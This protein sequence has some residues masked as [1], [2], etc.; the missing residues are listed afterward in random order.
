MG[1]ERN[2]WRKLKQV[3]PVTRTIHAVFVSDHTAVD[4]WRVPVL[5][6]G[7][8]EELGYYGPDNG[9]RPRGDK[10][11]WEEARTVWLV[12]GESVGDPDA[13]VDVRS[14][15]ESLH[16]TYYLGVELDGKERSWAYEAARAIAAATKKAG[17]K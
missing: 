4:I 10:I 3:V 8:V 12:S 6:V 15:V 11:D 9:A 5:Y 1:V 2:I 14:C 7:L 17:A 13:V 16:E